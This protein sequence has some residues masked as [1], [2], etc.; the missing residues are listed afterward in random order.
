MS[1]YCA[2]VG[3]AP[4]IAGLVEDET[5][6][7]QGKD[8]SI[9]IVTQN[10]VAMFFACIRK[11]QTSRWPQRSSFSAQDAENKAAEIAD[12]PVNPNVL[13]GEVWARRERGYL[14]SVEEGVFTHWAFGRIVLVG[15]SAHKVRSPARYFS[16][17]DALTHSLLDVTCGSPWG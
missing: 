12:V 4:M 3:I 5:N 16:N 8:L 2:L 6:S 11:R 7:I 17:H 15:D 10:R 9:F 14:C 1:S 13:F